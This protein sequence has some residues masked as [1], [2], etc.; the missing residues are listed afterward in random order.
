LKFAATPADIAASCSSITLAA[1]AMKITTSG[2]MGVS[3][4]GA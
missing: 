4:S 2:S 1:D 3:P